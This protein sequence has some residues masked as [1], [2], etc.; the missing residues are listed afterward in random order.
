MLGHYH[1]SGLQRVASRSGRLFRYRVTQDYLTIIE[2][3]LRIRDIFEEGLQFVPASD[4]MR[5]G[6]RASGNVVKETVLPS[7]CPD[8]RRCL[9]RINK[10]KPELPG[11]PV[12]QSDYHF[13]VQHFSS[14]IKLSVRCNDTRKLILRARSWY[15]FMLECNPHPIGRHSVVPNFN[16]II[17][18]NNKFK[19]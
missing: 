15:V 12:H 11:T 13:K 4:G 5:G 18:T 8:R 10:H 16:A 3:V 6:C 1:S 14:T 7:G 2:I 19:P 9:R 17:K